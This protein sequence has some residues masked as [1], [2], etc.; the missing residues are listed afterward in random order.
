M[1]KLKEII[2]EY[3]GYAECGIYFTLNL[4]GD[5]METIYADDKYQIDICYAYAYFEVFGL[6]EKEQKELKEYYE[7]LCEE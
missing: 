1:E 2:K 5:P 6:D 4:V 3:I 7:G